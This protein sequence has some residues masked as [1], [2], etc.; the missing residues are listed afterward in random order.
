VRTLKD[1]LAE[2]LT[3]AMDATKGRSNDLSSAPKLA[4]KAVWQR[5]KRRG[6]KVSARQISYAQK[7]DSASAVPAE[8]G[9]GPSIDFVEAVARA[10]GVQPWELILDPAQSKRE[11]MDDILSS[12]VAVEKEDTRVVQF[13]RGPKRKSR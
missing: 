13:P 12:R 8:Q 7:R 1:I 11:I 3:A 6:K 9:V 10:L 4:K 2:N 5:G